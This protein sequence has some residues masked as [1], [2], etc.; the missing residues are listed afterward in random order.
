MKSSFVFCL[1]ISMIILGCTPKKSTP[2]EGAWH[3][4]SWEEKVGDSVISKLSRDYTGSEIK[5]FSKNHELFVGRYKKDSTFHDNCGGGTYKLDGN[6]F[7]ESFLYFPDQKIV[8]TVQRWLVEIK[9]DTLIQ[10]WPV[11]E[12]WQVVKSNYN[13]QKLTRIE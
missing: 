13:I 8:G 5:I 9:N 10:T 2:I 7:E 4:V 12:N 1:M 11:D 6:H 3:V